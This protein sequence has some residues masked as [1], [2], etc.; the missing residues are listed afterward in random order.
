MPRTP[1][2]TK[3]YIW[4]SNGVAANYSMQLFI[5]NAFAPNSK[6]VAAAIDNIHY[7]LACNEVA[8]NWNAPLVFA[9]AALQS[10]N[11]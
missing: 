8:I 6:Y 10:V 2:S 5:A 3:D 1:A 11:N 4:G 9:L 7:L